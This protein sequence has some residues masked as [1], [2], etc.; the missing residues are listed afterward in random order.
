MSFDDKQFLI[1][2]LRII[3]HLATISGLSLLLFEISSF[4]AQSQLIYITRITAAV[5]IFL[6]IALTN[7]SFSKSNASFL[8]HLVLLSVM[9]S[10][11]AIV[12][13]IPETLVLNV[14]IVSLIIF[15]ASL[16]LSWDI[17]H[18]IAVA[19]YYNLIFVASI[20]FNNNI[21]HFD[22]SSPE[23]ISYIIL[24]SI[25]AI[26]A[27]TFKMIKGKAEDEKEKIEI[28]NPAVEYFFKN[29]G[30]GF[31]Q[32]DINGNLILVNNTFKTMFGFENVD[33]IEKI[34][35]L[36]DILKNYNQ[37]KYLLEN[38]E[39]GETQINDILQAKKNDGNE[40]VVSINESL[41]L[42]EDNT[43]DYFIGFLTDVTDKLK[44]EEENEKAIAALK[45]KIKKHEDV[46]FSILKNS[47][48]KSRYL[49]NINHDVKTPMNSIMGFLTLIENELYENPEELKEFAK[50]AKISSDALL[51]MINNIIDLA[52]IDSENAVAE[53]YEFQI[54]D[55]LE[56][57]ISIITPAVKEKALKL[58]FEI[59]SQTPITLK[60]DL[61]KYRLIINNILNF[62]VK[63]THEGEVAISVK[64]EKVEND[65]VK[66]VTI[67]TDTG[68][69]ISKERLNHLFK[70]EDLLK[71]TSNKKE[72]GLGLVFAKELVKQM[73]GKFEISSKI[74]KG[75]TFKYTVNLEY[76]GTDKI[77][78]FQ[79]EPKP[80]AQIDD[81][82]PV[83]QPES[84]AE[85]EKVI[86]KVEPQIHEPI[87]KSSKRILLVEDNPISQNIELKVL[88]E[89]GYQV[90]AVSNGVE[91]I[92]AI[93]SG[94]FKLVLM[95]VEMADM[96]GIE[97]TQRIRSLDDDIKNIPIIAVTAHSSMK[98]RERCLNSGM[99]DYIAKPININF[100][101]MT[102][103]Q[104][105]TNR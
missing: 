79:K 59:D 91:A 4:P 6:V 2:P 33:S 64:P 41:I 69:G 105:L 40:I 31:Y 77:G 98:D 88:R 78:Q 50:G 18:Q 49:S 57:S 32:S 5:I 80:V 24:L 100:L 101:K 60:G 10:F 53:L 45:T 27:A 7:F 17:K 1:A 90:D 8:A 52:S 68:K 97:A 85:I 12:Y 83:P 13:F 93:K 37:R 95:D 43:P 51:D 14:T 81:E 15:T 39:N 25:M 3:A 65:K 54:K 16:F 29:S 19:I 62:S 66:I 28:Q 48:F 22:T 94:K 36:K 96:D 73:G 67:V 102:I 34:N 103:D 35:L 74:N 55:E 75:S 89:V 23:A 92:E 21:K 56:K 104:W 86:Q 46:K 44:K 84:E 76:I 87:K 42:N 20:L 70:I 82:Q 30:E 26:I 11:G 47:E 58:K 63:S 71:D 38:Y 99:N 61:I 72:P 9:L